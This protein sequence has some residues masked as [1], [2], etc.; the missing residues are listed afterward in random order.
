LKVD[1]TLYAWGFNGAGQLATGNELQKDSPKQ[2]G[3]DELW[4]DVSCSNGYQNGTSVYGMHT[5]AISS[6]ANSVC[7]AGANYI[8]QLGD[9]TNQNA[10]FFNCSAALI[11]DVEEISAEKLAVKVYPNPAF[12]KLTVEAEKTIQKIE[13]YDIFGKLVYSSILNA[14]VATL[15]LAELSP[16]VYMV[17]IYTDDLFSTQRII[18]QN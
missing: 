14:Q 8:Y 5:L 6:N 4:L 18:I 15:D 3:T 11:N 7:A 17:R 13:V 1:S 12:G 16:G 9:G 10:S 2:V